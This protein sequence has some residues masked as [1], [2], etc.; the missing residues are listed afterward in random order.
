MVALVIHCRRAKSLG[1]YI[2]PAIHFIIFL[3]NAK[4]LNAKRNCGNDGESC[5]TLT[6]LLV[7]CCCPPPRTTFL[8]INV[9]T[10]RAALWLSVLSIISNPTVVSETVFVCYGTFFIVLSSMKMGGLD[11]PPA[12]PNSRISFPYHIFVSSCYHWYFW[13]IIITWLFA[14]MCAEFT[15]VAAKTSC[16]RRKSCL[17]LT[18]PVISQHIHRPTQWHF[19]LNIH[20]LDLLQSW[21]TPSIRQRKV[22]MDYTPPPHVSTD[23]RGCFIIKLDSF[24]FI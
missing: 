11:G 23:G 7:Q 14:W 1:Q 15:D 3:R 21:G 22:S 20:T 9:N 6:F 16:A 19:H 4:K 2:C 18:H 10:I 8:V 24:N 13:R 5:V 12:P 17:C